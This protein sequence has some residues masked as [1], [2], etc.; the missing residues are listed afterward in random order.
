M[1]TSKPT[2]KVLSLLV[3][4]GFCWAVAGWVYIGSTRSDIATVEYP[5]PPIALEALDAQTPSDLEGLAGKPFIVNFW[6]SWCVTCQTESPFL[7]ALAGDGVPLVGI[8]LKDSPT[9]AKRWLATFGSPYAMSFQDPDGTY[10]ETLGVQGAPETFVVDGDGNIRFH[11][12]GLLQET[13]WRKRIEPLLK[14]LAY[15]GEG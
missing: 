2:A 6:A 12:Q 4:S 7:H 1:P 9:D 11:Y 13:V 15:R 14:S 3:V 5:L 8:A 10:A